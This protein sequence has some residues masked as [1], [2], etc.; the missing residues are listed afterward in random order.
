MPTFSATPRPVG[1]SRP[2]G[3]L[4]GWGVGWRPDRREGES[5]YNLRF[6][7]FW[8]W[9]VERGAVVQRH[10][11]HFFGFVN[12]ITLALLGQKHRLQ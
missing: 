8:T 10:F 9:R 12:Q 11:W 3:P 2:T 5:K 6:G 1:P 4:L 7:E